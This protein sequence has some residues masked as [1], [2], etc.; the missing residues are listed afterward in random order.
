MDC[1]SCSTAKWQRWCLPQYLETPNVLHTSYKNIIKL[2]DCKRN[3]SR[4]CVLP[5]GWE[6]LSARRMWQ[7]F[8]PRQT[9]TL[10]LWPVYYVFNLLLNKLNYL[11]TDSRLQAWHGREAPVETKGHNNTQAGAGR[12]L[13]PASFHFD[14]FFILMT[15]LVW[16]TGLRRLTSTHFPE[17]IKGSICAHFSQFPSL[18]SKQ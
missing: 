13:R 14:G 4:M 5:T 2:L 12:Y 8:S 10:I 16:L 17:T 3:E 9:N 11:R 15:F 7:L 1:R 6:N 18:Q